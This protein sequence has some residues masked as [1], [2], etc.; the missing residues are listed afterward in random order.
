MLKKDKQK[1][2]GGEWTEEG[3]RFFLETK[4]H[5]GTDADYLAIMK[6]YQ[7]MT[8]DTFGEFVAFFKEEGHNVNAI[9]LDGESALA[10]IAGHAPSQPYAEALKA[11]GAQ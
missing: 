5:D 8:A 3:M 10:V 4:S 7:H 11:V 9:N 2:F 1:V 6:A